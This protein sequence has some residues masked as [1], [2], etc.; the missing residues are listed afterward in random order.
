[1]SQ[2]WV[3]AVFSFKGSNPIFYHVDHIGNNV[4]HYSALH[5]Y[6]P[7][8]TNIYDRFVWLRS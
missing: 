7:Y 6:A 4:L 3:G 8:S 1:M 5:N 2:L